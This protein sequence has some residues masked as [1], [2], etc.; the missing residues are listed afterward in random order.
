MIHFDGNKGDLYDSE[1]DRILC[2][3][4]FINKNEIWYPT[5]ALKYES[6]ILE[7]P[8]SSLIVRMQQPMLTFNSFNSSVL[9][10]IDNVQGFLDYSP[11]KLSELFIKIEGLLH[12]YTV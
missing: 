7:I 9:I 5:V 2:G 4:D 6:E 8:E 3:M 1:I 10:N 11:S 12:Y